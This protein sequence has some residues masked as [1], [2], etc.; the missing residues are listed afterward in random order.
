[1]DQGNGLWIMAGLLVVIGVVAV[2]G[3]QILAWVKRR[4]DR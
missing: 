3:K 2:F 4:F 1:M